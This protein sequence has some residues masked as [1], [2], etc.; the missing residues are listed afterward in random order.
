MT[1]Q[2]HYYRNI[3]EITSHAHVSTAMKYTKNSKVGKNSG[4]DGSID[5]NALDQ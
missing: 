1:C 2:S 5:I 3:T 4:R